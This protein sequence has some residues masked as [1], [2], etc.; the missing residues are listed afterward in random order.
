MVPNTTCTPWVA[1]GAALAGGGSEGCGLRPRAGI[2][3]RET[4]EIGALM[5][6]V[7]D[8]A[9]GVGNVALVLAR[10]VRNRLHNGDA[11]GHG[12]APDRAFPHKFRGFLLAAD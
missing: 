9:H 2:G 7:L 12:Q 10:T 1:A 4:N 8:R 11:E 3:F 5:G 6:G